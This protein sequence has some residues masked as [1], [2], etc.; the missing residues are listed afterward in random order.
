[1]SAV[2]PPPRVTPAAPE[3]LDWLAHAG[4]VPAGRMMAVV[5]HPD[6]ETV[7]L[8]GQLG[9]LQGIELVLVTDG[10]PH[11]PAFWPPGVSSRAAY[12]DL[13]LAEFLSAC[14]IARVRWSSLHLL[15]LP[16]LTVHDH[17]PELARQL[18]GLF[19]RQ[20]T[21]LVLTHAYEGGHPDHDATALAVHAAAALLAREGAPAPAIVE[22]GYY[23]DRAGQAVFGRLPPRPEGRAISVRLPAAQLALKEAMLR[24]HASQA[25]VLGN[26]DPATEEYRVSP[27][28][29]FAVLPN[30][31]ALL[32]PAFGFPISAEALVEGNRRA[33]GALG[34]GPELSRGE[35]APCP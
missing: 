34:L 5:A 2:Q 23:H 6:D 16:D 21:E 22:M 10:A 12:A 33:L 11:D 9:R 17:M 18:A 3:P 31:G 13:R 1:M 28:P 30:D 26:F 20:G 7:A 32:Y 24:A 8:G 25:A 14:A 27:W 35:P 29:D 4:P 19:R 15:G